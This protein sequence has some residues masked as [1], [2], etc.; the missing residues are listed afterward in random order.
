[1]RAVSRNTGAIDQATHDA[2]FGSVLE[3]PDK[4][5]LIGERS[6]QPV[7]AARFDIAAGEARISIFLVP[8]LSGRGL[9]SELLTAAENWLVEQRGDVR[10]VLAEVLGGNQ[11]SHALFQAGG[12]QPHS[13]LYL[14]RLDGQ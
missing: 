8:G 13:T 14:K 1:V 2:W 5:L 11:S 4:V 12:Y 3:D 10:A 7:G 6:G 9:G